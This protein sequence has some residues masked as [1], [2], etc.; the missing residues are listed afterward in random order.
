VLDRAERVRDFRRAIEFM[1]VPLA[2][3]ETQRVACEAFAAHPR[4]HSCAVKAT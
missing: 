3:A 4:K 1:R 2:V